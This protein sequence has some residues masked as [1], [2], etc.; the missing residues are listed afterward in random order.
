MTFLYGF[1]LLTFI[2]FLFS[3]EDSIY[4]QLVHGVR[5]LDVRVAHYPSTA[6]KFWVNHDKY[7]I[8]PLITLLE[9]VKRF[10]EETKEIVFLDFH[11]FPIGFSSRLIHDELFQFV[12][13]VLGKHLVPKNVPA[14]QLTP[15]KLWR[16]N[17]TIVITYAESSISSLNEYL[18]P[19]LV[20]VSLKVETC[21]HSQNTLRPFIQQTSI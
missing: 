21:L 19:Y 20:H 5:Y 2:F 13:K 7:R 10:V 8:R 1:I 3:Q 9:D 16:T 6:E 18:W 17:K 14:S 15:N 11:G 4:D 12:W